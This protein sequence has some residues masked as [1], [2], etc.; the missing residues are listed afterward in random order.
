M[1]RRGERPTRALQRGG[2]QY[3]EMRSLDVG[4]F[5]PV[6]VNRHTL[7][8]LEAFAALCVLKDSPPIGRSD[9]RALDANQVLV[10]RR[11]REP[12]LT[13]EA[14]GGRRELRSW[15]LQ[16]LDEMEGVCELLDHGDA[17]QPYR[18]ALDVQRERVVDA[19]ATPS[20]R[21]L[22]ELVTGG[23]AFFTFA[24]RL[25][26]QHRD[27]FAELHPPNQDRLDAFSR[28]A[29]E[30]HDAQRAIER[31]DDRPFAEYVAGWF[32]A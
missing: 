27:Y 22:D 11:G 5:D 7:H 21:L 18:T 20:A 12:G 17:G 1:P 2:V 23:E 13:L 14:D 16:L 32:S 6:G 30:S 26:H 9:E 25:S 31:A 3:V 24:L 29:A 28:E 4:L 10:A 8:F 19:G 15:A